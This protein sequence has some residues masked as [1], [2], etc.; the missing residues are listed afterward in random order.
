MIERKIKREFYQDR[1]NS[2][3]TW[4]VAYLSGGYYLRQHINGRQFGRGARVTKKHIS[5]IGIFDY[6][7]IR[8]EN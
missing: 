6:K 8:T 2:N 3:K 4:E 7:L 5:S 1:W